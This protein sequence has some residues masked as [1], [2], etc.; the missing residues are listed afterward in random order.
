[1]DTKNIIDKLRTIEKKYK[2]IF[3]N[4]HIGLMCISIESSLVMEANLSVA[5]M[6]GYSCPEE[7]INKVYIIDLYADPVDRENFLLKLKKNKEIKNLELRLIKKDNSILW[8]KLS[9]TIYNDEG[10]VEVIITDITNEKLAYLKF[11]ESINK[12]IEKDNLLTSILNNP[13]IIVYVKDLEGKFLLLSKSFEQFF[14]VSR[15]EI[16]NITDRFII[17]EDV[18]RKKIKENDQ[19]VIKNKSPKIFQENIS[20]NNHIITF[21][22]AKFPIIDEEG[23][24]YAIGGV[25]TDITEFK[26]NE[27]EKDRVVE[28]LYQAQKMEVIGS[29]AGGIAH[30]F[31]NILSAILGYSELAKNKLSSSS[32]ANKYIDF[33]ITAGERAKNLIKQILSL[34]HQ[35][36]IDQK[37][38]DIILVI[39]EVLELLK[40]TL[41]S[42]IEITTDFKSKNN[43]IFADSTQ[44]YQIIMN[45]CTNSFHAM[46]VAGGKL[47]IKLND[48]IIDDKNIIKYPELH[49]GSYIELLIIDTGHGISP[50]IIDKIFNPFFTTKE[51]G[52]GTGLGLAVIQRIINSYKGTITVESKLNKGTTFSI[53][54]PQ[55]V[56]KKNMDELNLKSEILGGTEHILIVDDEAPLVLLLKEMLQNIGYQI[57]ERISSIDA[58]EAFKA[59]PQS[60]DLIITDQTMPNMTGIEL[61]REVK[62]IRPDMP[63]ILCSGFSEKSL[64][65]IEQSIGNSS[66]LYKPLL[67]KELSQSI[68]NIFDEKEKKKLIDKM[69]NNVA[70]KKILIIDD[71]PINCQIL[72]AIL[73]EFSIKTE[74]VYSGIE[75]IAKLLEKKFDLIFLDLNMPIMNGYEV[76]KKIREK[77]KL[78]IAIIV[79]TGEEINGLKENM[80]NAGITNCIS[81][82]ISSDQLLNIIN[83]YI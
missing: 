57:T 10:Y 45:L 79:I 34:S 47:K 22:S 50:D 4:S 21:L 61:I 74:M 68:R 5:I 13:N 8:I 32:P 44:I 33:V 77:L 65:S 56:E 11:E 23:K 20:L 31:N 38:I 80:K 64:Q 60:Y 3:N 82:P 26:K 66:F 16:I 70:D 51:K 76:A 73:N 53:L 58:L 9:L 49:K 29:L 69:K 54:L 55:S 39:K 6:L 75:G 37:P 27:L 28:M 63:I 15:S 81:K 14:N 25:S 43:I 24:I 19:F 7:L 67:L 48:Y 72:E 59:N 62:S 46:N 78:D 18:E 52:H 40:A 36:E 41:P 30:D 83:K 1:M 2:N 35:Q 12:L 71:E 17:S 42:T